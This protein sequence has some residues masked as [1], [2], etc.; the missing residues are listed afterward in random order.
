M[1]RCVWSPGQTLC[2][3]CRTVGLGGAGLGAGRPHP[4][5][6]S[7]G[8]VHARKHVPSSSLSPW[9][10]SLCQKDKTLDLWLH[11][12]RTSA[13]PRSHPSRQAPGTT[14]FPLL[15]AHSPRGQIVSAGTGHTAIMQPLTHLSMSQSRLTQAVIAHALTCQLTHSVKPSLLLGLS[16]I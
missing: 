6:A 9:R 10:L 8:P 1:V 5:V 15:V 2:R 3:D 16:Q 14:G 7:R 4:T 12:C 13:S 11:V